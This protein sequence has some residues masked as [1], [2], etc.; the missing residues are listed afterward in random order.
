M[1]FSGPVDLSVFSQHSGRGRGS[2]VECVEASQLLFRLSRW[3]VSDF[4]CAGA[5][6]TNNPRIGPDTPRLVG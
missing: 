5:W 1:G 3:R 2:S 6:F 4:L